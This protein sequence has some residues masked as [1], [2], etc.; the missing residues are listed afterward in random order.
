MGDGERVVTVDVFCVSTPGVD[1]HPHTYVISLGAGCCV[2]ILMKE[3][4]LLLVEWIV[5]RVSTQ[6]VS[7]VGYLSG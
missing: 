3:G 5:G 1:S 6:L 7:V 2:L 4:F